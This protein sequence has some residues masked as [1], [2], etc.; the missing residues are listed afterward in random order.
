MTREK[1]DDALSWAGDDDPTLAP[2]TSSVPRV[3]KVA[4]VAP[5]PSEAPREAAT[6]P[7][8]GPS[9]L[10][11]S[12][13]AE[14]AAAEAYLAAAEK[15]T[16]QLSSVM[17]ISYGILGGVY[18]LE[19]MGWLVHVLRNQIAAASVFQITD[20]IVQFLAVASA[21][22]WFAAALLLTRNRTVRSRVG[23]LLLGA[24]VLVPWPFV[25]G[26]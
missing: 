8:E 11:I 18:F 12:E 26:K 2:A 13:D 1:D 21:P 10:D 14:D 7:A 23:W 3:A 24:F 15:D 5:V 20:Q 22:L 25:L 17:L 4:P 19:T 9:A 6:E 16:A